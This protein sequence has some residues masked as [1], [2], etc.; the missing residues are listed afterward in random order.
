MRLRIVLGAAGFLFVSCAMLVISTRSEQPPSVLQSKPAPSAS[1]SDKSDLSTK[2]VELEARIELLEL[3]HESDKQHILKLEGRLRDFEVMSQEQLDFMASTSAYFN[4]E[5]TN[6]DGE[7]QV[8]RRKKQQAD[9]SRIKHYTKEKKSEYF[10]SAMELY[11]K[12]LELRDLQDQCSA[13]KE[14]IRVR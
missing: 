13:F 2:I 4:P 3:D 9:L 12:R 6:R 10:K 5:M 11:R 14:S 8:D 7:S 1:K